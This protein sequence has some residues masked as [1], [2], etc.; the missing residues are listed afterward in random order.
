MADLIFGCHASF[1]SQQKLGYL[2]VPLLNCK[3]QWWPSSI[4]KVKIN[5]Q[6]LVQQNA[7]SITCFDFVFTSAPF[8][9]NISMHFSF[10]FLVAII[11]GVIPHCMN[12]IRKSHV[13]LCIMG[14]LL[15]HLTQCM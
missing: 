1:V 2:Q 11:N 12:T 15:V 6:K 14:A 8:S 5:T 9:T 10:T 7:C 4:L 3:E 13:Q